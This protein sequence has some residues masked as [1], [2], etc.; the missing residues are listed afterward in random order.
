VAK[1]AGPPKPTGPAQADQDTT[2]DQAARA[3][4]K[5]GEDLGQGGATAEY[6]GKDEY[7][8]TGGPE[9]DPPDQPLSVEFDEFDEDEHEVHY[10]SGDV[11]PDGPRCLPP[12]LDDAQVLTEL[13]H[14]VA[15]VRGDV[16]AL[17]TGLA[18]LTNDVAALHALIEADRS[19]LAVK[20]ALFL[21][22]LTPTAQT[23]GGG[24]SDAAAF[25]RFVGGRLDH[26]AAVFGAAVD[27]FAHDTKGADASIGTVDSDATAAA[28]GALGVLVAE[29]GTVAARYTSYAESADPP[30][31]QLL[32]DETN[33]TI[34]NLV[35][36]VSEVGDRLRELFPERRP[37]RPA[38]VT[39]IL[40]VLAGEI[41]NGLYAIA[42][43]APPVAQ[44]ARTGG[45]SS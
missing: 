21:D 25:A 30:A 26:L 31:R 7:A 44:A 12:C 11:G 15:A 34:D 35:R 29:F 36:H 10:V 41:R 22:G 8:P 33:G 9:T 43:Q 4:E 3:A 6:G 38:P 19:T 5:P 42:Q 16:A 28:L 32:E 20:A 14:E 45:S 37:L 13:V 2:W 24:G 17:S 39:T 27:R 23:G 40:N 18:A 1:P